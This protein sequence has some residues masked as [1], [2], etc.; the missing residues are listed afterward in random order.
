LRIG[1]LGVG[2]IGKAHLSSYAGIPEAEIVGVADARPGLAAEA[3]ATVGAR[4][5]A[6]YE[7]LVEEEDV[8]LVDVCLPTAFH[9][10]VAVR[11][12][13]DGKHVILEKPMARNLA[14]A[15]EIL[16]AFEESGTRLF[17][18]HV[19]RYFP[20]YVRIKELYDAGALGEV[21][22]V[23]T[24]RKSPFLHGWND[25]YADRRA[26]G[27]VIVDMLVHDFDFLRWMLG[28]VERVYAR[29]SSGHEYTRMDYALVTLRFEGG[30]IAHVEGHWGYPAPFCYAVEVAGTSA[31]VTVDS[32]QQSPLTIIA[33]AG[34]GED[35]GESP[36]RAVGKSPFQME[37]EH[38]VRCVRTGEESRVSGE[39]GY[40]ALRL[41]LAAFE[42]AETG[43]PVK[44]S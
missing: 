40:E 20:E 19:V 44:L 15:G 17:V 26:S 34:P 31:L 35:G 42:S 16:A 1:L 43:R 36:D 25:W 37:L 14:D 12:A 11:A 39:D 38:F 6:S 28:P 23:R 4:P 21:G 24:S 8:E 18:G 32:T 27:G 3:A 10:D 2:L 7:E 30:A 22:V 9:R 33:N 29:G 13:R 5:Y 41:G